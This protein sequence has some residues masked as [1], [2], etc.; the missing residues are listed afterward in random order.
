MHDKSANAANNKEN[1]SGLSES[2]FDGE[3][4]L[5][6]SINTNINNLNGVEN[7]NGI[8]HNKNIN[9]GLT[10]EEIIIAKHNNN[11]QNKMFPVQKFKNKFIKN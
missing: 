9:W 4:Q 2:S 7:K 1:L 10:K 6:H 11:I 3:Y 8:I 5:D